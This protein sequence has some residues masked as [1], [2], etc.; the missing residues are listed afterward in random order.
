M[1]HNKKIAKLGRKKSHRVALVTNLVKSLIIHG[2]IDTTVTKANVLKSRID[3]IMTLAKASERVIAFKKVN[4]ILNDVKV[5][6][7]LF[8]KYLVEYK[9]LSSGY[10][11]RVL[12]N[13]RKGDNALLAR[14]AWKGTLEI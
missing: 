11:Q 4:A 5:T 12:L 8:D 3:K 13:N 7:M 14:I 9:D 1:V 2:K 6:T 10:T